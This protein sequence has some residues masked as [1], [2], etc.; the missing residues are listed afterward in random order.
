[1]SKSQDN[2]IAFNDAPK[3]MFGKI[4]S[5]S[6]E[7]MWD[8]YSLLLMESDANVAQLK[9][10]HPMEAKKQLAVKLV[11]KLYEQEKPGQS[12]REQFEKVFARHEIP[13]E[14]PI[15]KW[16]DLLDI[17]PRFAATVGNE[18][19]KA[20]FL[21]TT[22]ILAAT[23]KLLND[24]ISKNE[25]RRRI[26]QGSVSISGEKIIDPQHRFN[27]PQTEYVLKDGKRFFVKI[28]P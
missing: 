11:D 18:E 2:Y 16:G 9:T 19:V 13:D 3:E 24:E 21:L 17:T 27:A 4:M 25:A 15:L 23:H 8:Y 26:E 12:E 6:D 10:L 28:I 1:M 5:I 20:T 7:V 22:Q 14:M